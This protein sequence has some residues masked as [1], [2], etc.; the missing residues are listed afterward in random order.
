MILITNKKRRR[1]RPLPRR[2]SRMRTPLT[3]KSLQ[4]RRRR[5][6]GKQLRKHK[7]M[8]VKRIRKSPSMS[9]GSRDRRNSLEERLTQLLRMKKPRE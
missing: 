8:H 9:S 2:V 7:K 3:L 6:K 1:L 4:R 5:K